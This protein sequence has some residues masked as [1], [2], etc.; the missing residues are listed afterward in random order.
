MQRIYKGKAYLISL[1]YIL[2][3]F[4][5]NIS[6][7]EKKL[8]ELKQEKDLYNATPYFQYLEDKNHSIK[9]EDILNGNLDKKFLPYRDKNI[10]FG[11]SRSTFHNIL[12]GRRG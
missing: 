8:L 7:T 10:N 6:A 12:L 2:L 3:T 1:L 5:S 4:V 9:R 11:F